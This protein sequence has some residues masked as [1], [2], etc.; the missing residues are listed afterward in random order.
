MGD[1]PPVGRSGWVRKRSGLEDQPGRARVSVKIESGSSWTCTVSGLILRRMFHWVFPAASCWAGRPWGWCRP[2]PRPRLMPAWGSGARGG[3]RGRGRFVQ[4]GVGLPP[5]RS[6]SQPKFMVRSLATLVK[7]Q[8]AQVRPGAVALNEPDP[9]LG[10]R[11]ARSPRRTP[12][13]CPGPSSGRRRCGRRPGGPCRWSRAATAG[14]V[15]QE[16]VLAVVTRSKK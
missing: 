11:H 3:A 12:G 1:S 15:G 5:S 14:S 13:R 10:P 6:R 2:S 9:D 4:G 7:D 8:A 16:H